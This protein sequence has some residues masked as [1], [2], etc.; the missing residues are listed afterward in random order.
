MAIAYQKKTAALTG[1]VAVEEAEGLLEWLSAAPKR[2][3]DLAACTH[4]HAANLQ[5]MMAL[6]PAISAWPKD[7]DLRRWL[8]SALKPEQ[9]E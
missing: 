7:A 8:E 5:V 2:K 3:L 6:Q 4:L 9:G 1:A